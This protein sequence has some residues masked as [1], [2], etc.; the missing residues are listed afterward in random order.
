[1]DAKIKTGKREEAPVYLNDA[2]GDHHAEYA[3]S[4]S[5]TTSLTSSLFNFQ[6]SSNRYYIPSSLYCGVGG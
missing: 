3:Q 4:S 1:M 2:V 6:R 5:L